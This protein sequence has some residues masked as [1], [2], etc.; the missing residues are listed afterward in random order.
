[1]DYEQFAAPTSQA[2]ASSDAVIADTTI[3]PSVVFLAFLTVLARLW[4][5]VS[6]PPLFRLPRHRAPA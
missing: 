1:V 5:T 3:D 4:R 6:H 2:L